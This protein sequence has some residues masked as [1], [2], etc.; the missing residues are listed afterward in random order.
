MDT[1]WVCL[2]R[3]IRD[4]AVFQ[5]PEI[6][7]LWVLCII[8]ANH[9][10]AWLGV[11][12][13]KEPILVR[14]GQFVTGRY[15]L[16]S[17]YYPDKRR[18]RKSPY[19]VWRWLKVLEKLQNLTI[20]SSSKFSLVTIV[21]YRTYNDVPAESVQVSVQQASSTRATGEQQASNRRAQTTMKNNEE[22]IGTPPTPPPTQP[23]IDQTGEGL[24]QQWCF[25]CARKKDLGIGARDSVLQMTAAFDELLRIG[26]DPDVL[27][28]EILRPGRDRTEYLHDFKKRLPPPRPGPDPTTMTPEQREEYGRRKMAETLA[29]EY[30]PHG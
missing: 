6:L 14:R 29:K 13:Q 10:D 8:L 30:R 27:L 5:D 26:H 2:H 22:Q 7:K 1:G 19:T 15:E 20:K 4:S 18:K 28:R 24:A 23:P 21:N 9:D 12:G 11:D 25:L 16:H 17:A 3:K